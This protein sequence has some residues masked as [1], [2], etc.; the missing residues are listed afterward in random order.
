MKLT[1]GK[2]TKEQKD[3][4]YDNLKVN[5][6]NKYN[7]STKKYQLFHNLILPIVRAIVTSDSYMVE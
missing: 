1:G 3:I 5:I 4:L 7:G 2:L 6:Y